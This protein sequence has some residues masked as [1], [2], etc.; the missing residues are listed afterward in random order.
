[1]HTWI[2]GHSRKVRGKQRDDLSCCSACPRPGEEM[3]SATPITSKQ[4][5]KFGL[6]LV[7]P[8]LSL[9]DLPS[10]HLPTWTTP[11]WSL[12]K[13]RHLYLIISFC[14]NLFSYKIHWLG[15]QVEGNL[16]G[17]WVSAG[18]NVLTSIHIHLFPL[19]FQEGCM[20][21]RNIPL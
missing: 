7:S 4:T 20:G 13:I 8:Y 9:V 6:D 11:T 10:L 19:S 15:V 3:S 1:M 17:A 12:E 5:S 18:E 16:A 21:G 2:P 14:H